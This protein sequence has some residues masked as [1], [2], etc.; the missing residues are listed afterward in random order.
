MAAGQRGF[1]FGEFKG[2]QH[3][4]AHLQRVINGLQP[5][6]QRLPVIVAEVGVCGP[7][8][9]DQVVVGQGRIHA[10]ATVR[11]RH[12]NRARLAQQHFDIVVLG[13]NLANRR[14]NFRRRDSG[15]RHL[16][17]Q[18]LEG[19]VI[20]AVHHGDVERKTRQLLRGVQAAK[21]AADDH[22]LLAQGVAHDVHIM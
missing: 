17:Q 7:G 11:V 12:V 14:G 18:R 21:A 20:R 9:H 2:Q 6:R 8:G 5:R 4:A 15:G 10:N 3:A 16:V 1:A 22:D 19:V 13:K